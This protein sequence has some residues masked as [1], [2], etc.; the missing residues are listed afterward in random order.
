MIRKPGK[1]P[2]Q[3]LP[4][5]RKDPGTYIPGGK[6]EKKTK[7]S[8]ART[9][10]P[11]ATSRRRQPLSRSPSHQQTI[12]KPRSSTR[13]TKT[14]TAKKGKG[15]DTLKKKIAKTKDGASCE[16]A[17]KRADNEA[18]RLLAQAK[19]A[20]REAGA[21]PRRVTRAKRF[22]ALEQQ[23]RRKAHAEL[24]RRSE[25]EV[26]D[27][28]QHFEETAGPEREDEKADAPEP[29][30]KTREVIMID[31]EMTEEPKYTPSQEMY[32]PPTLNCSLIHFLFVA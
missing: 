10:T 6:K 1:R 19:V 24:A 21:E 25:R 26:E 27:L 15:L 5:P 2:T 31:I 30:P 23:Q 16:D 22:I 9:A 17:K 20:E 8:T 13:K 29:T 7:D 11:S 14:T 12:G 32:F 3:P 28:R 18:R 4:P